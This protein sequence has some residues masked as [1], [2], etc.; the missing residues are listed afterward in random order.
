MTHR[1]VQE[2][3]PLYVAGELPEAEL[4]EITAHLNSCEACRREL[5]A[6]R[7]M[8]SL[9]EPLRLPD[10][11]DTMWDN[12]WDGIYNRIERGLGWILFSLGAIVVLFFGFSRLIR[13]M[14]ADPT[15][16]PLIKWGVLFVGGG[17]VILLVSVIREQLFFRKTERYKEVRR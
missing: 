9:L 1:D 8:N 12:Y 16:P 2:K 10:P 13:D 7:E 3:L 5:A 11:P 17:L 4:A 14:L 15:V 6:F